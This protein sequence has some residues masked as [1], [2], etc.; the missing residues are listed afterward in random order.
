MYEKPSK[1]ECLWITH[2]INVLKISKLFEGSQMVWVCNMR[3]EAT[4]NEVCA[5][6]PTALHILNLGDAA[7]Y[8]IIGLNRHHACQYLSRPVGI[9]RARCNTAAHYWKVL[10]VNEVVNDN[11][12]YVTVIQCHLSK[13]FQETEGH[14]TGT[15][16]LGLWNPTRGFGP[17]AAL[18]AKSSFSLSLLR[19]PPRSKS[20]GVQ[21]NR[22][23]TKMT[24]DDP[25]ASWHIITSFWYVWVSFCSCTSFAKCENNNYSCDLLQSVSYMSG[26]TTNHCSRHLK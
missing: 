23:E 6:H 16:S 14:R 18:F 10:K 24:R 8:C 3:M 17:S 22:T 4:L 26:Q 7:W 13:S 19:P 25:G 20:L 15:R 2:K 1:I 5:M 11:V 9:T 12:T 21:R